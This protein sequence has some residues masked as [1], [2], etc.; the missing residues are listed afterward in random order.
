MS[1]L[2]H[3][4]KIFFLFGIFLLLIP[5]TAA[6]KQLLPLRDIDRPLNDPKGT[7]SSRA[8]LDLFYMYTKPNDSSSMTLGSIPLASLLPG[9]AFTDRLFI[10]NV[11]VPNICYAV[12]KP[13]YDSIRGFYPTFQMAIGGGIGSYTFY[14]IQSMEMYLAWKKPFSKYWWI[15][16]NTGM[17]S[18]HHNLHWFTSGYLLAG[19]G[20]QLTER[21]SLKSSAGINFLNTPFYGEKRNS[22]ITYETAPIYRGLGVTGNLTYNV[23]FNSHVSWNIGVGG[24]TFAKFITSGITSSY[25]LR[26]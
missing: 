4:V 16:G 13:C 11:L 10:P 3:S 12:F 5:C 2:I 15:Y 7:W 19:V 20:W 21:S 17:R 14:S 8:G 23:N 25:A 6:E 18:V 24:S 26:W 1:L 22:T 9:Y